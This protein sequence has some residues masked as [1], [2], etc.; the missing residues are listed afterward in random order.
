M[1]LSRLRVTR[2]FL[3]RNH[4]VCSVSPSSI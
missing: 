2:A 3:W 1:D 4:G